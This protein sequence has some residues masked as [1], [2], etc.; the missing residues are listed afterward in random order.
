MSRVMTVMSR[1]MSRVDEQVDERD[2]Q[3]DINCGNVAT[4]LD[5]D[6]RQA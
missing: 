4:S 3:G 2:E 1:V 6:E 5:E